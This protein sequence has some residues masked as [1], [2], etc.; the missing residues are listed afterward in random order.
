VTMRLPN[1][2]WAR[3]SASKVGDRPER[4]DVFEAAV[5]ERQ[6]GPGTRV[7][8]VRFVPERARR[9]STWPWLTAMSRLP[10]SAAIRRLFQ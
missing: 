7:R 4:R 10:N 8:L 2:A 6:R 3:R 9:R 1:A 5:G